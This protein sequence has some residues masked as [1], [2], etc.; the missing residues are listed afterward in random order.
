MLVEWDWAALIQ[1]SLSG[2]PKVVAFASRV[3]NKAERNY[4][5][6]E[7]ECLAVVWAFDKWRP[8]LELV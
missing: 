3:L 6:T 8:Y 2:D 7:L 1:R 4:S 5:T